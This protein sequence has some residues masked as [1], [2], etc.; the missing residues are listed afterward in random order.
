MK[1]LQTISI[2]FK[3]PMTQI[4]S[5]PDKNMICLVGSRLNFI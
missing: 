2:G 3:A 5:I 1:C 4:I